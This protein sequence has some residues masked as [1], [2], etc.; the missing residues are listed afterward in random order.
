MEKV[1]VAFDG[2]DSSVK[3]LKMGVK[4]AEK[5]GAEL[6]LVNVARLGDLYD[7][8]FLGTEFTEVL[9]SLKREGKEVTDLLIESGKKILKA[10]SRLGG[11]LVTKEIVKLGNPA[12]E[13]IKTA[14]EE[15]VD[16]IVLGPHSKRKS[17]IMGSVGREVVELSPCSV[18]VA[19]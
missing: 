2:S 14:K 7:P 15:G 4:L 9:E 10:G 5:F 12:E 17:L 8:Q 18:L 13:I 16:I 19:R 6:Y 1:L 3:A 11:A